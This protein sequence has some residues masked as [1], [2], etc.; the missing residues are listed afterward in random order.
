MLVKNRIEKIWLER[1]KK[2]AEDNVYLEGV[3]GVEYAKKFFRPV[4]E[5]CLEIEREFGEGRGIDIDVK[6]H[7]CSIKVV[8]QKN[9]SR[10]IFVSCLSAK[11]IEITFFPGAEDVL[12]EELKIQTVKTTD[13]AIKKICDWVGNNLSLYTGP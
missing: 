13:G 7:C 4:Y 6:E 9:K 5:V 10:N 8:G 12:N 2:G 1:V 11:E 3:L